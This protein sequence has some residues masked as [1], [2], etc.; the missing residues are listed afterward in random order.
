MLIESTIR[1]Q[2]TIFDT[3]IQGGADIDA[4]DEVRYSLSLTT[5]QIMYIFF[6]DKL[7]SKI[8]SLY[9]ERT[10]FCPSIDK[11]YFM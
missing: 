7:L 10:F 3:L 8:H 9:L 5:S 4:D 2:A 6:E 1:G 11:E